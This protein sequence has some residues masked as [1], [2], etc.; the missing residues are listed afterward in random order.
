MARIPDSD[1]ERLRSSVDLVRLIEADGH[2]LKRIGKDLACACP[3]H[4]GDREPSLIVSPDKHLFSLLCLRRGGLADRLGDAAARRGVPAGG[5][6][7]AEGGEQRGWA[8]RRAAGRGLA[9]DRAAGADGR[10]CRAAAGRGGVLS[11]DLAH[12]CRGPGLSRQARPD[13]SG[14]D[15]SVPARRGEPHA[16]LSITGEAGE[17][18]GRGARPVAAAGRAAG[19]GSR[20]FRR[21]AGGAGI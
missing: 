19:V 14:R 2:S 9:R 1:I 20:A 8:E 7:A 10:G 17:V 13:A 15:R 4:E 6:V 11:P 5:G 21:L 18:R 16:G 3:F 12:R